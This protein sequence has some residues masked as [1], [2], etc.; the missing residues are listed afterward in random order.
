LKKPQFE[1][2]LPQFIWQ[3]L[4][5]EW[6][7]NRSLWHAESASLF[8][9]DF[10][11]GKAEVFQR[12]GINLPQTKSHQQI[13][14]FFSFLKEKEIK[15]VYIVGDL[16]HGPATPETKYFLSQLQSKDHVNFYW[17]IGNHDTR[18]ALNYG[19][20]IAHFKPFQEI[21]WNGIL[22]CHEPKETENQPYICGHIHPG[23]Q[24]PLGA[25]QS[26]RAP[27]GMVSEKKLVLPAF[28][29][30]TG[31]HMQKPSCSFN[32]FVFSANQVL[33]FSF[34]SSIK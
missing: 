4:N 15:E 13:D 12:A 23:I 16:L 18:S 32:Y 31:L 8:L 34:K 27:C 3:N 24:L 10:H 2:D 19:K 29:R 30:L 1:S 25:K 9:S 5:W 21:T 6:L 22:L 26:L 7:P 28:G 17:I 11:V 20:N 33:K 14:G